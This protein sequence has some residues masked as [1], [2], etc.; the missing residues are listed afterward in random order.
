MV[1]P[2]FKKPCNRMAHNINGMPDMA[3]SRPI[4]IDPDLGSVFGVI[5]EVCPAFTNN[6]QISAVKT[7]IAEGKIKISLQ[8][9]MRI[10]IGAAR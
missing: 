10:S 2:S 4:D 6:S 1:I 7:A 9:P 3:E 5:F 8:V